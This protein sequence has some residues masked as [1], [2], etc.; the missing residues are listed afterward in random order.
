MKFVINPIFRVL[1]II[2]WVAMILTFILSI[3]IYLIGFLLWKEDSDMF[4]HIIYDRWFEPILD[5]LY[6]GI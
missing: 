2:M 1:F 4:S 3:P 5:Y 6:E